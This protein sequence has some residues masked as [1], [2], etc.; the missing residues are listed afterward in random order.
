M[1]INDELYSKTL[2]QGSLQDNIT[3]NDDVS[4]FNFLEIYFRQNDYTYNSVKVDSPLN[5]I[6]N[7]TVH[8]IGGDGVSDNISSKNI[9]I[10]SNK[11]IVDNSRILFYTFTKSGLAVYN[12]D[13]SIF[14]TKVIGIK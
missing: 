5:K 1:K 2:F 14:I 10:L 6:V 8:H 7:L 13:D 9:R 4:K 11:I 3:L 12:N